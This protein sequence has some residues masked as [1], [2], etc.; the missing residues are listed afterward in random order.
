MEMP[1]NKERLTVL[2]EELKKCERLSNYMASAD[3]VRSYLEQ[4]VNTLE[5]LV[6]YERQDE[7]FI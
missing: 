6:K 5:N 4:R 7:L 1:T 2:K 3:V